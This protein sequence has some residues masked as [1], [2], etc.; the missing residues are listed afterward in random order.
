[1]G[2]GPG[3]S[4]GRHFTKRLL[5]VTALL[6]VALAWAP[7]DARGQTAAPD[8]LDAVA[9]VRTFFAEQ[10]WG[11]SPEVLGQRPMPNV[12]AET[13]QISGGTISF[14]C[15]DPSGTG[16]RD[17]R[18]RFASYPSPRFVAV[19]GGVNLCLQPSGCAENI[20]IHNTIRRQTD[21]M[22]KLLAAWVALAQRRSVPDPAAD[23]LMQNGGS[24][25]PE[26]VRRVQVQVELALRSNRNLDAARL[27]RDALRTSPAWA[28]GH[29]NLGLLYGDLELY[30]EAIT[31]MRR[32]LYLTPNAK[33]ARAVQDKTYEWEAMGLSAKGN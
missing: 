5:A 29:Y 13:V 27:Y 4:T 17:Y 3:A 12:R 7:P 8:V 11:C 2:T 22:Q 19:A 15:G 10:V 30:P 24:V 26:T 33:D 1:M 16:D 31:E 28:D 14:R 23:P 32:Y 18:Y 9:T 6:A 21:V 25:D 20:K